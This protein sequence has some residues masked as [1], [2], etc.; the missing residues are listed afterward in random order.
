MTCFDF[1]V[2]T[3]DVDPLRDLKCGVDADFDE[4]FVSDEELVLDDAHGGQRIYAPP[5]EW[6][7]DAETLFDWDTAH[8]VFGR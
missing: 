8:R 2:A 7:W 1:S 4:T 6:V 3:P 5:P